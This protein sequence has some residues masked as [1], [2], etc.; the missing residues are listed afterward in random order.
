[1]EGEGRWFQSMRQPS[2]FLLILSIAVFLM[3]H[4]E[5]GSMPSRKK[6]VFFHGIWNKGS[7]ANF[8]SCKEKKPRKVNHI[9]GTE[10][11]TEKSP[12]LIWPYASIAIYSLADWKN[13][14]LLSSQSLLACFQA[15]TLWNIF[16][17]CSRSS[18]LLKESSTFCQVSLNVH[19]QYRAYKPGYYQL[20]LS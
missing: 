19:T 9:K 4:T 17:L 16:Y 3:K 6:I 2:V 18:F 14:A 5:A 15:M 13:R 12:S 7:Y 1:M 20:L 10:L 8:P 11:F